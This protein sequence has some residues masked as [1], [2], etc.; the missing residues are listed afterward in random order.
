M[1]DEIKALIDLG[2]TNY[3]AKTY[4]ALLK[5]GQA[6]AS[7]IASSA[8]I[9]RAKVYELLNSLVVKGFCSEY[10]G[11]T[12]LYEPISPKEAFK[13]Y[14]EILAEK[15]KNLQMTEDFFQPIYDK[16]LNARNTMNKIELI[17]NRNV[18][19][20]KVQELI[21]QTK[22][23]I[24]TFS[25]PPYLVNEDD[26]EWDTLDELSHSRSISNKTLVEIEYERIEDFLSF[27]K[28]SESEG[29]EIRLTDH[30]PIKFLIFDD[31]HVIFHILEAPESDVNMAFISV[32]NKGLASILTEVFYKHWENSIT[33]EEFERNYRHK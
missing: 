1:N 17:L 2:L 13:Y 20:N 6:N 30:V 4:F 3:E 27:V 8:G 11:Q 22:K 24:L 7:K 33:I 25:K 29:E 9:A 5:L 31:N 10:Q 26:E 12:K 23:Q 19:V 14:R 15:E 21:P 32:P 18:L 16:V 28:K